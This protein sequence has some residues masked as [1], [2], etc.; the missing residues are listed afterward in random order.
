MRFI[1]NKVIKSTGKSGE[2]LR[3][4]LS[5]VH[6]SFK[7]TIRADAP[8]SGPWPAPPK[9]VEPCAAA[10]FRF[11]FVLIQID[12]F[13]KMSPIKARPGQGRAV[14]EAAS[15]GPYL[16][17]KCF[18]TRPC[19]ARLYKRAFLFPLQTPD[20]RPGTPSQRCTIRLRP[21]TS[22]LG[23]RSHHTPALPAPIRGALPW[24]GML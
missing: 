11:G 22:D 3:I 24:T 21:Q 19:G 8:L 4:L 10:Y 20:F 15:Q 6:L 13:N 17:I 9:R 23:P 12:T 14:T 5:M 1:Y 2:I 16:R 7:I 18:S